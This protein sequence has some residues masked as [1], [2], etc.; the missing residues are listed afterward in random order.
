M[1][2]GLPLGAAS[3]FAGRAVSRGGRVLLGAEQRP[4]PPSE[5]GSKWFGRTLGGAC[6]YY[7]E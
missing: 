1:R 4:Q 2:L 5:L 3:D 6:S 7:G